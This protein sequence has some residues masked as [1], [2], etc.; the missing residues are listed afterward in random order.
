MKPKRILFGNEFGAGRGHE[1]LLRALS[2]QLHS[3]FPDMESRFVLPPHSL[4][5]TNA[6]TGNWIFPPELRVLR[7]QCATVERHLVH[8]FCK[9][10]LQEETVLP[11]RLRMWQNEISNFKPDLIIADYAPSL[12]MTAKGRVPCFVVGSGYTLPPPEFET[13]LA[14]DQTQQP[15]DEKSDLQWLEKL[16]F[17]LDQQGI[18]KLN[19]LPE[20]NRGDAYGLFTIPLFDIYWQNRQQEYMGVDHPGGSPMPSLFNDGSALVYMSLPHEELRV[21]DGLIESK[22]PSVA[23]M[24]QHDSTVRNRVRGT[25]V[26]LVDQPFD[27]ARDLPGRAIAVHAG[28]LGMSAAGVYAG[29]PQVGLYQHNEGMSNCRSFDIA[30]IGVS[31]WV[32]TVTPQQIADLMHKA[33]A[34]NAMRGYATA[35]SERYRKFRDGNAITNALPTMMKLLR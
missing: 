17:V 21:I 35:L 12:S 31:A 9:L 34:S 19:F 7:A 8:G 23:F 3:M 11:T 25:N 10:W 14:I 1:R 28:S 13:C 18:P 27:L 2:N 26:V 15:H 6:N 29:I 30:Q 32:E 24:G 16:N 22:I 5:N 20:V 4:A 33:K